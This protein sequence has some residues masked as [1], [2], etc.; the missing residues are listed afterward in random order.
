MSARLGYINKSELA[1]LG[2]VGLITFFA[3]AYLITF[4]K[5]IY[6]FLRKLKTQKEIADESLYENHIVLI[7]FHRIGYILANK[8]KNDNLLIIE[9]NPELIKALENEGFNFI[10]GDI[11]DTDVVKRANIEKAKLVISTVPLEEENLFVISMAK[12]YKVPVI[13]TALN[14]KDALEFYK[15]GANYVI[16]PHFLGG[17]HSSEFIKK[18]I[19]NPQNEDIKNT[20]IIEME[21]TIKLGHF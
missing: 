7:G 9:F 17:E 19:E 15:A 14:S 3:S 13:V 8:F 16:I 11:V 10:Y 4:S 2:L 20:H 21:K 5:K 12:S 18:F 1:I 6:N